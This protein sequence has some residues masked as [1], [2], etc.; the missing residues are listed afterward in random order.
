ML[1]QDNRAHVKLERIPG[2]RC[3]VL[4]DAS[5]VPVVSPHSQSRTGHSFRADAH[6]RSQ[7]SSDIRTRA[8]GV[9]SH[10]PARCRI[11]QMRAGEIVHDKGIRVRLRIGRIV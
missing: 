11:Q 7:T 3:R 10:R 9:A 5:G 6:I 2:A 4:A 8:A 1:I